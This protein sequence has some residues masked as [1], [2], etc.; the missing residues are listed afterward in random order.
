MMQEHRENARRQKRRP[1][2]RLRADPTCTHRQQDEST[3]STITLELLRKA[4]STATV[5]KGMGGRHKDPAMRRL[6]DKCEEC[7][8]CHEYACIMSMPVAYLYNVANHDHRDELRRTLPID[9]TFDINLIPDTAPNPE[10]AARLKEMWQLA[11][12]VLTPRQYEILWYRHH[13]GMT[14]E[15]TG[16]RLSM[17]RQNVS[18]IEGKSILRLQARYMEPPPATM[19]LLRRKDPKGK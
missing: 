8:A 18:I 6:V 19:L 12:M 10:E 17:T 2:Q 13:D 5:R 15:E 11:G 14:L 7:R 4:M 3:A 1:I 9:E 16:F